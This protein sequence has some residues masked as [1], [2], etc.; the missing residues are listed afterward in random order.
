VLAGFFV[1][2]FTNKLSELF[3]TLFATKTPPPGGGKIA[4]KEPEKTMKK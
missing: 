1:D 2:E 4:G 3:K